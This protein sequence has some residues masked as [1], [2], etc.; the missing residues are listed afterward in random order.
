[1]NS[2]KIVPLTQEFRIITTYNSDRKSQ[3]HIVEIGAKLK[4]DGTISL[5][6]KN[7]CSLSGF[8]FTNSDPDL[9]IAIAEMIKAFAEDAKERS[10]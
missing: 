9:V 3:N 6:P 7:S 2:I 10:E 8:T 5:V 1:M 4:A